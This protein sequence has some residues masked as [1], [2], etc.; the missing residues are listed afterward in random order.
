[1]KP[2]THY[3]ALGLCLAAL[4]G[5]LSGPTATIWNG[6]RITKSNADGPDQLPG[7]GVGTNWFTVPGSTATNRVVVPMSPANGSVLCRL[8]LS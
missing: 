6:P 3:V 2:H 7:G 5:P 8:A 1:V 4:W